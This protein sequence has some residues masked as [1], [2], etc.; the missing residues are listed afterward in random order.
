MVEETLMRKFNNMWAT[1]ISI[2]E[3]KCR[4]TKRTSLPLYLGSL[5]IT[6]KYKVVSGCHGINLTHHRLENAL[7][8]QAKNIKLLFIRHMLLMQ[9]TIHLVS[10]SSNL[11]AFICNHQPA[12]GKFNFHSASTFHSQLSKGRYYMISLYTSFPVI[13]TDY[14]HRKC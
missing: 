13:K 7:R 4:R 8:N 9:L 11:R 6:A 10:A 3:E 12:D 5:H 14:M 1:C 2:H